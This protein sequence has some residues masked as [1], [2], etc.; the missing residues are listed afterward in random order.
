M[1]VLCF[2]PFFFISRKDESTH[3]E[4]ASL[5]Q[6]TDATLQL[7]SDE[8]STQVFLQVG[9][10]EKQLSTVPDANHSNAS[11]R[12]DFAVWIQQPHGSSEAYVV[13]Y[14]FPTGTLFYVTSK[15]MADVPRVTT[16]G[17]VVWKSWNGTVWDVWYFDGVTAK[18]IL[19]V[20]V[21]GLDIFGEF[22]VYS[23][24]DKQHEWVT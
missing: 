24:V 3:L 12:G 5:Q 20:V 17:K 15:G 22:V 6:N 11:M 10:E 19:D 7:K 18:K 2:V 1:Q 4:I 13:R 14:H 9:L 8:K 16:E 23:R 21:Y